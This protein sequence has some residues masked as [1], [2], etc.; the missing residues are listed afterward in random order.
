[1]VLDART[2]APAAGDAAEVRD[3]REVLIAALRQIPTKQR[4][5]VVLRYVLDLPERDVAALLQ[6]SPGTVKSQAA[7]GLAKLRTM[8]SL[9]AEV[10]R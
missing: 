8:P 10:G 6:V 9:L 1:V 5:V 2:D 4:E 3:Q 7:K